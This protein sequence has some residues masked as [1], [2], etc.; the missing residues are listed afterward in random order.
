MKKLLYLFAAVAMTSLTACDAEDGAPGPQGAPGP[1]A[2]VY[3]IT[4]VDFTPSGD[5]GI[6]FEYPTILA[7]DHLLV[8]RLSAV[9]G[10]ED[11]WKPLP[12]TFYFDD[13]TLDFMYGFDH[14]RFDTNIYME[15]FDLAGVSDAFR[16]DQVFRVVI[17]PGMFGDKSSSNVDLN[18]Y[19]AVVKAYG[20]DESKIIPLE[21]KVKAEKKKIIY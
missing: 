19:N 10:N 5:F 4:N 15:G 7:S 1:E 13:G 12:E 18:D 9:E 8:Y 20:I 2:T 17:I 3:E 11:V 6:F 16:L 14:T 21:A